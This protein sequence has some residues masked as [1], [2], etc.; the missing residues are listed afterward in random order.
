MSNLINEVFRRLEFDLF[1]INDN[2]VRPSFNDINCEPIGIVW[3]SPAF[4]LLR[5]RYQ[6][7]TVDR[8][9]M[10]V[11]SMPVLNLESCPFGR[12][13]DKSLQKEQQR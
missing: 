12:T 1:A 8:V 13:A 9:A 6:S 4:K 5:F 2:R 11:G 10:L 7:C 3:A